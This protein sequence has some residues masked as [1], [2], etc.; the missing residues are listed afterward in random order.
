MCI[1]IVLYVDLGNF[2]FTFLYIIILLMLL[3]FLGKTLKTMLN[4][5]YFVHR[6]VTGCIIKICQNIFMRIFSQLTAGTCMSREVGC[7]PVNFTD[8]HN[9]IM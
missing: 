8:V 1:A 6:I 5:L 9:V 7:L 2:S 3:L 4:I